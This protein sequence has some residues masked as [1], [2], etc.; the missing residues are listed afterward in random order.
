MA[1]FKRQQVTLAAELTAEEM[2]W[3]R[4]TPIAFDQLKSWFG[5]ALRGSA[6]PPIGK[7]LA[8]Q[9]GR[10]KRMAKGFIIGMLMLN[11]IPLLATLG[12]PG[13]GAEFS[14][15]A[16]GALAIYLPAIFLDSMDR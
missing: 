3:S 10:H 16:L 14:Y 1:E 15:S 4:S 2:T 7:R 12:E 11:A 13:F 9:A 8:D 5:N 6:P